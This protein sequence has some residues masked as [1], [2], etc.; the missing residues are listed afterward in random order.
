LENN[1]KKQL[2]LDRTSRCN[3]ARI[4]RF[5]STVRYLKVLLTEIDDLPLPSVELL[6]RNIMWTWA[7]K[8][9]FTGLL[10]FAVFTVIYLKG[11]YS[12]TPGAAMDIRVVVDA[13]MRPLYWIVLVLMVVTASLCFK[14]LMR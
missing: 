3:R 7:G 8:G 2:P 4:D 12:S 5:Q 11:F 6:R 14:L 13:V 10:F 1:K 9:I